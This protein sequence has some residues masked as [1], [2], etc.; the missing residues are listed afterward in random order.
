MINH[1]ASVGWKRKKRRTCV[2]SECRS[3]LSLTL[4][5][6][7]YVN[8]RLPWMNYCVIP[9]WE[10]NRDCHKETEGRGQVATNDGGDGDDDHVVSREIFYKIIRMFT[11]VFSCATGVIFLFFHLNIYIDICRI[12]LIQLIISFIWS[13]FYFSYQHLSSFLFFFLHAIFAVV[14]CSVKSLRNLECIYACASIFCWRRA[15][16]RIA[17]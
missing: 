4:N 13:S 9:E 10:K 14:R 11:L 16:K 12:G 2:T 3:S 17:V 8:P 1:K 15:K 6:Y 5:D 7:S